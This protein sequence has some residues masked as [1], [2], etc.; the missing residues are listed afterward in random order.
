MRVRDHTL[1]C[2]ALFLHLPNFFCA[3]NHIYK[4]ARVVRVWCMG[5]ERG[6]SRARA[7]TGCGEAIAVPATAP[8]VVWCS[9]LASRALTHTS[10]DS[11]HLSQ[12]PALPNTHGCR[13]FARNKARTRRARAY[14]MKQVRAAQRATPAPHDD[15]LNNA[16]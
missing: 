10:R 1:C 12:P 11:H 8:S 7:I 2:A 14:G 6:G 5:G 13:A 4:R 15:A 3:K 9:G 16:Q